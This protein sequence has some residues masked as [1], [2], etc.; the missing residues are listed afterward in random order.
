MDVAVAESG[1]EPTYSQIANYLHERG[2]NLS[3]S[4]WTYKIN[5]DISPKALH[6]ITKF[7]DEEMTPTPEH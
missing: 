2:T 1:T 5:G 7:L 4:R 3:R 6:A